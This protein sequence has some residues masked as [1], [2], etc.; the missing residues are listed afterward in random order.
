M[1][2]LLRLS[3]LLAGAPLFAEPAL[4]IDT[5]A[6]NPE[7]TIKLTFDQTVVK[8]DQIGKTVENTILRIEPAV[9]GHL[10]WTEPNVA[11]FV[12]TGVP[13]IASTFTFS[14][15]EGLIHLDGSAIPPGKLR[16]LT[17][18]PFVY[19]YGYW[20]GTTRTPR[21][22]VRF[23]DE[24]DPGS[25]VSHLEFVDKKGNR[26]AA[27]VRRGIYGDLNTPRALGPT[28]S[29]RFE[30]GH[31]LPD[32]SGLDPNTSILSAV[33][34]TPVHPLPVGE[35]WRLAIKP[36]L[37]NAAGT[38]AITRETGRWIGSVRPF[39]VASIRAVT[40][41]DNPRYISI[42]LS[43]ALPENVTADAIKE[44]VTIEPVPPGMEIEA[45]RSL[46]SIR[47]EYEG[48]AKWKVTVKRGLLAADG[49]AMTESK[50]EEIK[51]EHLSPILAVPSYAAAQLA[52]GSRT[53]NVDT[54]N[55]AAAR[56][57]VKRLAGEDAIR[58]I[59]GY[60][61]YSGDGPGRERIKDR[62]TL[63][64]SLVAGEPI[65]DKRLELDNGYDTSRR[66]ELN[67]NEVLGEDKPS[68]LLFVSI[69]GDPKEGVKGTGAKKKLTQVFLQLTDI[70]L[71]WPGSSTRTPPSSMPIPAD[72]RQ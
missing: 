26:V 49:L 19:E 44:F 72:R 43:K 55:I 16:T 1:K 47:G 7:T 11:S 10:K 52:K 5:G 6:F 37:P 18:A 35:S 46:I 33:T 21:Y 4:H 58:T 15:P 61:H 65:Y 53:Y 9:E 34:V 39:E 62:H 60:R 64:W 27:D 24:V 54:V 40:R 38:A 51:F 48:S 45:K 17:S 59:Q 31:K 22:F 20:R 14:L 32:P 25:V 50:S 66:I 56:I 41:V 71:A 30:K 12:R 69:E 67:W 68:S 42:G 57:R 8:N 36:G 70:G 29:Q 3:A 28:W 23:N 63:P 13:A 2:T